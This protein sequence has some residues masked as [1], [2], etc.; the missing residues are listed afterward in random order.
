MRIAIVAPGGV[1]G[2]FG[3]LLAVAGEEVVAV[4]RGAHLE[5]INAQGLRIEGA[6]GNHVARI[7]AIARGAGVTAGAGE[8][9]VRLIR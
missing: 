2:Y 5:A 1:G 7:V 8:P 6:R 9:P 4:A 3:G